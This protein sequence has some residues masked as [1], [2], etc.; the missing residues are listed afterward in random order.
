MARTYNALF[1]GEIDLERA[2]RLLEENGYGGL[3]LVDNG[4]SK[5]AR[6][7]LDVGHLRIYNLIPKGVDKAVAMKLDRQI[8]NL[9]LENCIALGDSLEDL[10][11]AREVHSFF[12]MRDAIDR[13]ESIIDIIG[14]YDNVYVT[15][16]K[17]NRG[18]AEVIKYLAH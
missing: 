8:R 13:D 16:Q 12:L 2:N 6:L 3:V 7:D 17:M 4:F 5:L 1:F 10:K 14:I 18:W 15:N 9:K 11:M